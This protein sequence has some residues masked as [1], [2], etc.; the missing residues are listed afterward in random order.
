MSIIHLYPRSKL[1]R[2]SNFVFFTDICQ[3]SCSTQILLYRFPFHFRWVHPV[4]LIWQKSCCSFRL[5]SRYPSLYRCS[6]YPH[7]PGCFIYPHISF[8]ILSHDFYF[9]FRADASLLWHEITPPMFDSS[10]FTVSH[11]GSISVP[12]A[13]F[14]FINFRESLNKSRIRSVPIAEVHSMAANST[15]HIPA[16]KCR[17]HVPFAADPPVFAPKS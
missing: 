7:A 8:F 1:L 5:V 10:F 15:P 13:P 6:S 3:T 12:S 14:V 17:P 2:T 16:G 4:P 11:R 9:L